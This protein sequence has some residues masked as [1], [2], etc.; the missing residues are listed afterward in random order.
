VNGFL[1]RALTFVGKPS[2]AIAVLE[3]AD[4]RDIGR[5]RGFGRRQPSMALPYVLTGNRVEAEALAV[6]HQDSP[7]SLAIVCA[8]L[9]DQDGALAALERVAVV[10]P[11][12]VAPMLIDPEFAA[13][14][15]D[16]RFIALRERFGLPSE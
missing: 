6:M 15:G 4:V 16:P 1:A 9:G 2:E 3:R 12:H 5:L 13:L 14:R 8:A 7:A 10:Q 11:H